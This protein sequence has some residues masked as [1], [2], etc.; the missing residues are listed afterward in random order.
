MSLRD[1]HFAKYRQLAYAPDSLGSW[2]GDWDVGIVPHANR[3]NCHRVH[4]T[5]ARLPRITRSL[6]LHEGGGRV[7][8]SFASGMN[9]YDVSDK[10]PCSVGFSP[11]GSVIFMKAWAKAH[12]TSTSVGHVIDER[13]SPSLD[14]HFVHASGNRVLSLARLANGSTDESV[15]PIQTARV[16]ANEGHSRMNYGATRTQRFVSASRWYS[17]FRWPWNR[18]WYITFL[19][20]SAL[21]L[22]PAASTAA[23][24]SSIVSPFLAFCSSS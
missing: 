24:S 23:I 14:T 12:A 7:G 19:N 1:S 10:S 8:W 3:L 22:Y 16:R 17:E 6:R 21:D 4:S 15:D 11:R 20:L 2:L 5:G 13:A 9:I 18:H